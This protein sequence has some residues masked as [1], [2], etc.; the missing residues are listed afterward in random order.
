MIAARCTYNVMRGWHS[1]VAAECSTLL[2][3]AQHQDVLG[4]PNSKAFVSH[5]GLHSVYEAAF[6]G[7]PLV[8]IGFHFESVCAFCKRLRHHLR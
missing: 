5:S 1:R 3:A 4:H 8:S 7:V 6:H 2:A